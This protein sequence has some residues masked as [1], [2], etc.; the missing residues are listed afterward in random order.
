MEGGRY[1]ILGRS[2]IDI[3]K[4][5]GE[6]ISALEIE[7]L[8]RTHPEI[9]DCAVVGLEDDEWGQRVAAAIVSASGERLEIQGL[10]AWARERLAPYKVPKEVR[11]VEEL[12]RNAMGKVFKPDVA[13]LFDPHGE[14]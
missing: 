5:G 7:E 2:S 10:L 12:P 4:C 3:I 9:E 13:R 1:K 11:I 8:L 14:N 6:K